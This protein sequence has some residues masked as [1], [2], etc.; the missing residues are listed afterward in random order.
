MVRENSSLSLSLVCGN[1]YSEFEENTIGEV[2]GAVEDNDGAD[3]LGQMLRD[4]KEDCG[5]K[6][7][8][9]DVVVFLS[10]IEELI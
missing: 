3:D 8:L 5:S 6:K 2:D 9:H 7:D 4:L 10:R 1:P